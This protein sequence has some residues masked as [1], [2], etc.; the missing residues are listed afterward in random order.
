M[1]RQSIVPQILINRLYPLD[2]SSLD[3]LLEELVLQR[4]YFTIL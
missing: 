2:V 3:Y 4:N 1:T